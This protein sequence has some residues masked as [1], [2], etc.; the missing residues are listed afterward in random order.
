MRTRRVSRFLAVIATITV[1]SGCADLHP[2]EIVDGV[3]GKKVRI[4]GYGLDGFLNRGE[5]DPE[6]RRLIEVTLRNNSKTAYILYEVTDYNLEPLRPA[7]TTGEI[8][9]DST[10]VIVFTP[11]I[12]KDHVGVTIIQLLPD[13]TPAKTTKKIQGLEPRAC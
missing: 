1:A 11:T 2:E 4:D 13:G 3:D 8:P 12:A 10:K 9:P 7:E 5:C 6:G